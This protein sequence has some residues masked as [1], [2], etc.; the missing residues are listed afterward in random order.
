MLAAGRP[1]M[2]ARAIRSFEAQTYSGKCELLIFDTGTPFLDLPLLPPCVGHVMTNRLPND[3]IGSLRNDANGTAIDAEVIVH[4]DS[5]DLSHPQR[6]EEQVAFLESSGAD[7]VGYSDMAVWNGHE[8]WRYAHPM[9]TTYCIGA[10]LCYWRRVWE[11]RPF[12]NTSKGE[13]F[14]FASGIKT[15]AISSFLAEPRF[16]AGVHGGNTCM[17][18]PKQS[19]EWKRAPMFDE[20][21]RTRMSA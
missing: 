5:D 15:A 14:Q 7:A 12:K 9:R 2:V 20:Y 18:V 13:D 4:W 11:K 19:T 10:T 1:E 6:I 3:T 21:C 16:I 17:R 8:A